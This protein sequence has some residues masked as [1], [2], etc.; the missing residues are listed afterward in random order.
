[1]TVPETLPPD[2]EEFV[3]Q[4]LDRGTFRSRD[5]LL[6]EALR[7][8]RDLRSRHESLREEVRR[9]IEQAD[10]GEAVEI[11]MEDVIAAGMERASRRKGA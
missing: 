11:D 10:Q 9:A 6:A 1:M 7:V 2:I 3:R 8:F 5:E 4:E